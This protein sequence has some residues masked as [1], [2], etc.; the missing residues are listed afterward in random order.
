MSTYQSK[1]LADIR[2]YDALLLNVK[3]G[4]YSFTSLSLFAMI[5]MVIAGGVK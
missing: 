5:L 1:K 3:I 4:F 2:A